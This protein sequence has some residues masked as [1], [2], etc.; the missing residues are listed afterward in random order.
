MLN[1][2]RNH[3]K[4][5]IIMVFC[6]AFAYGSYGSCVESENVSFF[7]TN[8][9]FTAKEV[10]H[11]GTWEIGG[12]F[13]VDHHE[14]KGEPVYN[15]NYSIFIN[16]QVGYFINDDLSLGLSSGL[17][18]SNSNGGTYSIAPQAKYYFYKEGLM[19]TYV[20]QS[21]G[22]RSLSY[23]SNHWN[24]NS[25]VGALYLLSPNVALGMSLDY[26]YTLGKNIINSAWGEYQS[27]SFLGSIHT[28][29]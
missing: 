21:I 28:Y 23:D 9:E 14:S 1:Q 10:L 19:A 26:S 20:S 12:N 24:G 15:S 8:K 22:Y 18:Y 16:P 4:K 11:K 2:I 17:F 3:L 13:G 5:A 6:F 29:F 25:S 7:K 27:L